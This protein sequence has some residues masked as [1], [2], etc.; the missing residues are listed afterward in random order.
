MKEAVMGEP[1]FDG[2]PLRMTSAEVCA[3]GRFSISTLNRKR[4]ADPKWLPASAVQGGRSTVFD[5]T[6]VLKALGL[7]SVGASDAAEPDDDWTFDA[8]AFRAARSRPVRDGAAPQG[9]NG[10]R[11]VRS[12][13]TAPALRLV[14][15]DPA[16][17]DRR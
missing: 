2:L 7:S 3:L 12:A 17:T 9:R 11:P 6:D 10:A 8:D 15:G 5:R 13:Q 4:L 14:G 16:A 1:A